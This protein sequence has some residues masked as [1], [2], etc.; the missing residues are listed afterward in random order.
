MLPA[1]QANILRLRAGLADGEPKT[2]DEISQIYGLTR[3]RIRQIERQ[4]HESLRPLLE[5]Q[6][7]KRTGRPKSDKKTELSL[8]PHAQRSGRCR[9]S[10]F[11]PRQFPSLMARPTIYWSTEKLG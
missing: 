2:L 1:R 8:P 3:E 7:I 6:G 5:E 4:A 10:D 11:R 9:M